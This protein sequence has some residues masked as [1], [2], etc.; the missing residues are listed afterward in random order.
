MVASLPAPPDLYLRGNNLSGEV[1]LD[2]CSSLIVLDLQV[3]GRT[4]G[5]VSQ[6][7]SMVTVRDK[8]IFAAG[9]NWQNWQNC[10][11]D[12]TVLHGTKT[13]LPGFVPN[14]EHGAKSVNLIRVT[15][16]STVCC[17]MSRMFR[18]WCVQVYNPAPL[19]LPVLAQDNKLSGPLPS[20]QSWTHL[21]VLMLKHNLFTGTIP[22]VGASRSG[23]ISQ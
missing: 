22:P 9:Q 3:G 18:N 6:H 4:H 20:S 13:S 5:W 8:T 15:P 23:T 11:W 2:K 19:P 1:T 14:R 12:P 17:C 16:Q 7:C 10:T 21:H